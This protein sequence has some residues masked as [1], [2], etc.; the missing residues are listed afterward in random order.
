MPLPPDLTTSHLN[1]RNGGQAKRFGEFENASVN[2]HAPFG[3]RARRLRRLFAGRNAR[4]LH[5]ARPRGS[6]G[7]LVWQELQLQAAILAFSSGG[8]PWPHMG[9]LSGR[10][11]LFGSPG[12]QGLFVWQELQ[13]QAAILAFSLSAHP[14]PQKE[15][16]SDPSARSVLI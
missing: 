2:G 5:I 1:G 14:W 12:S 13:L 4:P 16:L 9:M 15:M 3:V 8:H 11:A 10:S 7:L 6:Q